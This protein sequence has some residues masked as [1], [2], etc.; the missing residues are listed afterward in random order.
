MPACI[1]P[2][3]THRSNGIFIG[4]TIVVA[5]EPLTG[6]PTDRG[7]PDDFDT[8]LCPGK[9]LRPRLLTG[10]EDGYGGFGRRIDGPNRIA[11]ALVTTVASQSQI[12]Q[13]VRAEQRLGFD[14]VD[15]E[16]IGA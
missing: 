2:E 6:R 16:A 1:G 15:R 7:L 4:V 8:V 3:A 9:M 12:F 14:M 11:T 10:I 5:V 13:V